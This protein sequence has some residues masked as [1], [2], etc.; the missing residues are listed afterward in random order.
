MRRLT[1]ELAS[2]MVDAA[3]AEGRRLALQ[4]LCVAVLDSGG[5]PL[6][7]KRDERA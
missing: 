4:P 7:L 1:L 6:A 3:L 5:H 2:L